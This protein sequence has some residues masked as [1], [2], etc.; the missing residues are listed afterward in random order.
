[1]AFKAYKALIATAFGALVLAQTAFG[2]V[3]PPSWWNQNDGFTSSF[4]WTFDKSDW[5]PVP[6]IDLEP[7]GPPSWSKDGRTAWFEQVT[8][9]SGVWGVPAGGDGKLDITF[10]N[11]SSTDYIKHVW[12][13]IDFFKGEAGE[14]DLEL[15]TAIGCSIENLVTSS[16]D[17]GNGWQRG[18]A[19]FDIIPQPDWESIGFDLHSPAG[20]NDGVYV[21]N[22]YFGTHCETGVPSPAALLP[23]ALGAIVAFRRR[24]R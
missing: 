2:Q 20:Q 14:L 21:D 1:M 24:R 3:N 18:T 4:G 8:D 10:K 12:A 22:F 23:F 11:Q 13:Q 7:Y 6:T 15:S 19:T 17:I 5:P 16:V 9:H